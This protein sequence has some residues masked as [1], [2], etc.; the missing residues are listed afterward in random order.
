MEALEPR[1]VLASPT[2]GEL[3]DEINI[4][5]GAPVQ[6]ALHGDDTDG[7]ALTY[8]LTSDNSAISASIPKQESENGHR[9]LRITVQG[10]GDMVFELFEDLAPQTTSR[11]IEIV[12]SGWYDN[13]DFHRIIDGFMIEGGSANGDGLTGTGTQIDDEYDADLQFTTSGLLAMAKWGDDTSDSQFFITDVPSGSYS[14]PR[15]LDFNYTIFGKLTEGDGVREAISEATTDSDDYPADADIV[16][17]SME[18]F[19]DNQN[20]VM[21]ISAPAGTYDSGKVTITVADENGDTATK[22]LT[23]N[24]LPDTEDN[25]PFL[26]EIDPIRLEI[27]QPYTF[28]LEAVDVEGDTIYYSAEL[29]TD[30][31]DITVE[32]TESGE[33]TI[34]PRNKVVGVAEVVFR[35]GPTADSV[36]ADSSGEYDE[37]VIDLQIV[38]IEIPP[39][40]PTIS[41]ASGADTGANDGTTANDNS[42]GKALYFKVGN[43]QAA[44]HLTVY[45]NGVEAP[46]N[47]VTR[48]SQGDGT[49][50]YV[51]TIRVLLGEAFEDGD[52]TLHVQQ[53]L[54]LAS[55]FGDQIL[56]SDLSAPLDFTV[57]TA[58]P[59]ITTEAIDYAFTGE[60]YFYDVDCSDEGESALSYAIQLPIPEGMS[61]NSE[62]GQILWIPTS[63][64]GYQQDVVVVATDGAGNEAQQAFTITVYTP[65]EITVE[66]EQTVDE[67]QTVSLVVTA[68]DPADLASS[69]TITLRDG[70]LP[71]NADYSLQQ[72]D[73]NRARFTWN[74]TE[75]D[76][77][78]VYDLVFG[79]TNHAAVISDETIRVT[80]SDVN[81]APEFTQVF[82]QWTGTEEERINLQ[83]V[84]KDND[85]PASEIAFDLFGNVPDGAVI[86]ETSGHLSWTPDENDGGQT[87]QF[88]VRVTDSD[89]LSAEHTIVIGVAENRKTPVFDLT[90]AQRVT[91]GE[92]LD[93]TV[94]AHDRD[95]PAATLQYEFEGEVPEGLTIDSQTGR[96]HWE[97]PSEYLPLSV[98]Q[99]TIELTVIAREVAADASIAQSTR[100]IVEIIVDDHLAEIVT[101]TIAFMAEAP[102]NMT[103]VS[104][105][106][107]APTA[108]SLAS[109]T[110]SPPVRSPV[111]PTMAEVWDDRGFFGTQ[112]GPTG[113]AGGGSEPG[114]QAESD[115][116]H[117]EE[118]QEG[119]ETPAKEKE[120][121]SLER[122]L[123]EIADDISKSTAKALLAVDNPA[124]DLANEEEP[125]T[126]P[127][128]EPAETPPSVV[129]RQAAPV[130]TPPEH[131]SSEP[132]QPAATAAATEEPEPTSDESPKPPATITA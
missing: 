72:L 112:F 7:D 21:M 102:R 47:E 90:A 118:N 119:Q 121:S 62:S 111:V 41:F 86:D 78:G 122:L 91:E 6:I 75:A 73:G 65:L 38:T 127:D 37:S 85:L 50:N 106:L 43:L 95:I 48:I 24:V 17:E 12:E 128:S 96:I 23:V 14:L 132:H 4:Y 98:L 39:T 16:I 3:P 74:T 28:Q 13:R 88:G 27:D 114:Q 20:A 15:G 110:F 31:D 130:A 108:V 49:A 22:T 99:S 44:S 71:A 76:G 29:L 101:G 40:Q 46:Y 30:T 51:A 67:L 11:I 131:D 9:S 34:T 120:T 113:A 104:T 70:V 45:F 2:L 109:P 5:A 1:W 19:S 59:V 58:P 126:Q 68:T 123:D 26:T 94:A 32:V 35:V 93:F 57:D 100:Q 82:D 97:V 107:A 124:E 64:A 42:D 105:P 10:Y 52:H 25:N 63:D 77:P 61:I 116:K 89:G 92:V 18:I 69:L 54:Q 80:V 36:V 129:D 81:E 8:T 56:A 83:F 55:S 115:E 60:E 53:S 33:V 103:R 87:F 117:G 84:A 125:N 79:V 66:G